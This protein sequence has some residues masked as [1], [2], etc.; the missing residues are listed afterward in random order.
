MAA[1]STSQLQWTLRNQNGS[2]QIPASGP[3]SPTHLDLCYPT[4]SLHG[5]L[6]ISPEPF[7]DSFNI[8]A[9]KGLPTRNIDAKFADVQ[10]QP[11]KST[12]LSKETAIVHPRTRHALEV[13][14]L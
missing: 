8:D 2:I 7:D 3:P 5:N 6:T 9:I 11:L 12:S 4:K 14:W 13:N 1:H 10:D